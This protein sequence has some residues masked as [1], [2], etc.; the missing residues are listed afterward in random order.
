M[1][2]MK[3]DAGAQTE[4]TA[5]ALYPRTVTIPFLSFYH[6]CLHISADYFTPCPGS[7]TLDSI[8]RRGSQTL[9]TAYSF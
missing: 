5:Q 6:M 4:S 2:W 1:V 7:A 9:V 3:A 8:S